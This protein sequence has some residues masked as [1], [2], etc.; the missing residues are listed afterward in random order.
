MFSFQIYADFSGY[1][2]MAQG[3]AKLLGFDLIENF[4][5]PYFSRSVGEFW[6]KWHRSLSAWL[7]EYIYSPLSDTG[8]TRFVYARNILFVFTFSG[9]WHGASWNFVLWGFLNGLYFLP[10]IFLPK[11]FSKFNAPLADGRWLP[12]LKEMSQMLLTFLLVTFSRVF[13]RSPDLA[14]AFSYLKGIADITVFSNPNFDLTCFYWVAAL[15]VFEW[16]QR[17]GH[18]ENRV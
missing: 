6:R 15:L 16:L 17:K 11:L 3:L 1:S 12:N 13:F 18:A 4:Q 9:L 14:S 8:Q 5:T 7:K 10:A 2:Q